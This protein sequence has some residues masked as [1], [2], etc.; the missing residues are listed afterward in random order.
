MEDSAQGNMPASNS[1]DSGRDEGGIS[2]F[3]ERIMKGVKELHSNMSESLQKMMRIFVVGAATALALVMTIGLLLGSE[4][5]ALIYSPMLLLLHTCLNVGAIVKRIGHC[6]W[7]ELTNPVL[8]K[9]KSIWAT[10]MRISG[11]KKD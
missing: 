5:L 11:R 10:A 4:F 9:D 6:A 7:E 2:C 1:C 3:A 8:N